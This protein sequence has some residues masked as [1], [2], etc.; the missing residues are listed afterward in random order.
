MKMKR[1]IDV[2]CLQNYVVHLWR[3]F[4]AYYHQSNLDFVPHFFTL[5]SRGIFCMFLIALQWHSF[6][7]QLHVAANNNFL[8][9]RG[10]NVW[11]NFLVFQ[12]VYI[13]YF[14]HLFKKKNWQK[15]Q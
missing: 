4:G 3:E 15:T 10:I 1:D 7:L 5:Y 2:V 6:I 12:I 13:F 8:V 11:S 9:D 14:L